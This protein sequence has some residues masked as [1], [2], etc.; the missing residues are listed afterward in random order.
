MSVVAWSLG[1]SRVIIGTDLGYIVMAFFILLVLIVMIKFYRIL[2]S[3]EQIT[4]LYRT[5][6]N[7][8]YI[9]D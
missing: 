8:A 9:Y 4:H 6:N 3:K 5:Q 1:M 7:W 2:N